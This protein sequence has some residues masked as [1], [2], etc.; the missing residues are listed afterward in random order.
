MTDTIK[1]YYDET[2]GWVVDV[3]D[4]ETGELLGDDWYT[5]PAEA[6]ARVRQILEDQQADLDAEA[7]WE[8]E[9]ARLSRP[10]D[11]LLGA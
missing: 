4:T 3:V 11:L 7:R 9:S 10:S 6:H 5:T 1:T 2:R 8:E